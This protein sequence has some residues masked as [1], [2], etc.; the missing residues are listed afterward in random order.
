MGSAGAS[1]TLPA[2]GGRNES[3]N[4][5]AATSRVTAS[6]IAG[7]SRPPP[8]WPVSTIGAWMSAVAARTAAGT[9]RHCG[10]AASATPSSEGITA[11]RPCDW[12][13]CAV[14]A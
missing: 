14:G 4:T 5:S 13:S 10:A 11:P 12:S 8:L 1:G 9:W 6:A 7:S 2:A 3:T